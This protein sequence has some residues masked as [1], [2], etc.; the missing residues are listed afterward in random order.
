[1]FE[2]QVANISAPPILIT[3]C[4]GFHL[5]YLCISLLGYILHVSGIHSLWA[6]SVSSIFAFFQYLTIKY[7][8]SLIHLLNILLEVE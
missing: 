3:L 7:N 4:P 1:M 6:L 2:E 5:L 8:S